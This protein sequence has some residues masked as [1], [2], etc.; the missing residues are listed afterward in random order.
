MEP[1]RNLRFKK[2][3]GFFCL[4]YNYGRF[5]LRQNEIKV[6]YEGKVTSQLGSG[7]HQ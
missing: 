2:S 7:Q 5:A 3:G 6:V 4:R 1:K